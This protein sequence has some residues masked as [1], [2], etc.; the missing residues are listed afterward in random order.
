MAA[1]TW[2]IEIGYGDIVGGMPWQTVAW[3]GTA[4]DSSLAVGT[5]GSVIAGSNP[6]TISVVSVAKVGSNELL[7]TFSAPVTLT[8]DS[9]LGLELE[10]SD[11]VNQPVSAVQTSA[12]SITLTYSVAVSSGDLVESW[13]PIW[14]IAEGAD[15]VNGVEY[16]VV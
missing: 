1:D 5:T 8:G 2:R 15:I 7:W 14:G 3:S 16:T 11:D 6:G 9:V 12:E 10:V 4:V 13:Q